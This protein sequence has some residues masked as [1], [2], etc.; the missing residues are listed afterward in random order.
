MDFSRR[1]FL[2]ASLAQFGASRARARP[3][4]RGLD[5]AILG[6]N[7]YFPGYGLYRSIGILRDLGFQS[8]EMHP[9]GSPEARPGMPPGFQFDRISDED[10]RRI[11]EA[12]RPFRYVS[13][14][15]PWTDT[16]YFSPFESAAEFGVRQI[17]IA[18]EA[19]AFLGAEVANIHVQRAAHLSLEDAWPGMV[20]QFRRWGDAA[21]RH[22]FRLAIETGYPH[23]VADFVRL[24]REIDHSHVGATVDVG[25]QKDFAELLARVPP[26]A[27]GTPAGIRAYNDVT[28]AIIDQLGAKIFHMHI[29]DIEP[30]TWAEHKPLIHGFVD[31]PRLIAKLREIEYDGL[32]IFEIGGPTEK[33]GDYF[34]DAKGKLEQYLE[35]KP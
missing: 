29:H 4:G 14:H 16:P 2:A 1:A 26:E 24:I 11:K 27:K 13:T 18:L 25:H 19:T 8:I 21:E 6:A 35:R 5:P 7:P 30:A 28:H 15:L 31:Y 17:D 20:Q 12:L 3:A 34:A 23:S 33:L 22:G 10:K 9:M 32:L